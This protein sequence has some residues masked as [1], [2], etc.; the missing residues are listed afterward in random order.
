MSITL[1]ILQNVDAFVKTATNFVA[2][3]ENNVSSFYKLKDKLKARHQL[4][5]IEC[6]MAVFPQM[7]FENG[8]FVARLLDD[9]SDADHYTRYRDNPMLENFQKVLDNAEVVFDA[10]APQIRGLGSDMVLLFKRQIAMRRTLIADAKAGKLVGQR[11]VER[12]YEKLSAMHDVEWRLSELSQKYRNDAIREIASK[13]PS[14][15]ESEL[16]RQFDVTAERAH[17]PVN[18]VPKRKSGRKSS[19][20]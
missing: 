18:D 1:D 15:S 12:I 9:V 3:I 8:L 17:N 20:E 5:C 14:L 4:A 7:L 2:L 13:N 6:I 16:A 19:T 10:A 11:D